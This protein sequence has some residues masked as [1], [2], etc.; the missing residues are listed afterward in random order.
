MTQFNQIYIN[1]V[2]E[3]LNDSV[4]DATSITPADKANGT[5]DIKF[6]LPSLLINHNNPYFILNGPCEWFGSWSDP[7]INFSGQTVDF[8]LY[9]VLYVWQNNS[10]YNCP[11]GVIEEDCIIKEFDMIQAWCKRH[12]CKYRILINEYNMLESLQNTRYANWPIVHCDSFS[13]G[14]AYKIGEHQSHVPAASRDIKYKLNCFTFRWDQHRMLACSFLL[15]NNN[16]ILTHYHKT[17][18][19]FYKWPF[20]QSEYYLTLVNKRN[21]LNHL[22][23]LTVESYVKNHYI[24]QESLIPK[25]ENDLSTTT[26]E[27]YYLHSFASVVCETNYEYPWGQLSEKF[28]N[29]VKQGNAFIL[30]AGPYSLQ[31]AKHWGFRTFDKWWDESYDTIADPCKRMDAVFKVLEEILNYSTSDL[32]EIRKQMLPT[33]VHNRNLIRTGEY[34]QNI[35][36]EIQ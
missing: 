35:L 11:V 23:P 21:S 31:L 25:L 9:E 14:Y 2:A 17:A 27:P 30:L 6:T 10:R 12:N 13:L 33:L 32:E 29:P 26:L 3:G 28:L 19:V 7:R 36:K 22:V 4:I 5:D 18:G 8:F 20:K 34:R 16:V 15:H 24:A 1:N